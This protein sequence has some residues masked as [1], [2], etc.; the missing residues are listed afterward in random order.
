MNS[1]IAREK[2]ETRLIPLYTLN[3][4]LFISTYTFLSSHKQNLKHLSLSYHHSITLTPSFYP[5]Y[6]ETQVVDYYGQSIVK[7]ETEQ[8]CTKLVR[9]SSK[10]ARKSNRRTI[11][12]S[13]WKQ[14]KKGL[15]SKDWK[16]MK[17]S[18]ALGNPWGPLPK[19]PS[20]GKG[21]SWGIR[22]S[23][24]EHI[25]YLSDTLFIKYMSLFI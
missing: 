9:L 5:I 1:I 14:E 16:S 4:F 15:V 3:H 23:I 11:S 6:Q 13:K 2:S 25:Y 19:C 10:K 8:I 12:R 17:A 21:P 7:C 20:L 24:I 18:I 22:N